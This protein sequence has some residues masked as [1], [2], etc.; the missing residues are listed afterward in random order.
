MAQVKKDHLKKNFIY[1]EL[2]L[3]FY[4]SNLETRSEIVIVK[5]KQFLISI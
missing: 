5:Y 3:Y 2:K 1:N 4:Y